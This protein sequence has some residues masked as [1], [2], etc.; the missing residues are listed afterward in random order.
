MSVPVV[1]QAQEAAAEA[2]RPFDIAPQ[3]VVDALA[4]FGRQSGLQV[5]MDADQVRGLSTQGVKGTMTPAQALDRLLASTGFVARI[6]GRIVSLRRVSTAATEQG[7]AGTVNLG[8]LRV[9]GEQA[10]GSGG[11]GRDG[12]VGT[13]GAAGGAAG[14]ADEIFA[15]PRA[16][17]ILTREEMDRAPA[18]HASDLLVTSPG[19]SSAV[20]RLDPGLSVNIR[21][22]QDFGRVNMMIDGMRQNFVRNGHQQRNGQVYVDPELISSVTIERGP[23]TDVHGAGAIAG[24]VNFRTLD[25][26][27]LLADEDDRIGARLRGSTGL[28]AEGNGVNFIGSAALAGRIG[29]RLELLGGYSRRSIGDYDVGRHGG[30][31]NT[32]LEYLTDSGIDVVNTI[33]YA[34]QVQDS[35]LFKARLNL[36]EDHWFQFTYAGTWVDYDNV[37]DM[38]D[39]VNLD[40]NGSPWRSLGPSTIGSE[41]FGLDY[42]FDPDSEWLDLNLK[43]YTVR[44]KN[45]NYS[46][47]RVPADSTTAMLSDFAW[48]LGF[49]ETDPIP[50]SWQMACTYG[51]GTDQ[52]IRTRTYGVQLDN[53]ARFDLAAGTQL[54]VNFGG[55]YYRDKAGSDIV[56]D[57]QGRVVET[58]NQ[59][60][61]GEL[62]N[63]DG[64]RTMGSAFANFTVAND[65]YTVAAGVRYDHYWLI[66]DTQIPGVQSSYQNRFDRFLEATCGLPQPTPISIEGC[67]VAQAGGEEAAAAWF[68]SIDRRDYWTTSIY[69][70]R[71]IDTPGMYDYHVD[72]SRGRFLPSISAAVRP[73]A[74]LE[75]YGSWAKSWRPPAINEALM[76]GGHPGDPLA[77]MYPNP[78][79]DPEKTTSWEVGA[80][81]TFSG[82]ATPDD[83]L[84]AKVGYFN[85][86][87]RDYLYTSL[88]S[89]L[90]GD[91]LGILLGLGRV[92]FVNNRAPTR[93]QGLEFEGRYDAGSVYANVAATI[94]LGKRNEFCQDLYPVGVG[95]SKYDQP[96]EDGSITAD[97]QMAL[98]AGYDSWQAWAEDQVV[99][100]NSVMNSVAGERVDRVSATLGV[101]LFDRRLDTG[102]RLM[103]AGDGGL[104]GWET[105]PLYVWDSYTTL[106]WYGSFRLG[107]RF[108]FFASAQNLTDRRYIDANGDIMAQ[109]LAPG[110]TVQAGLQVKF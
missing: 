15:A 43:L 73:T 22:M 12:R 52:T 3:S 46:N 89:N 98:D 58:Y 53:T 44:T 20:N 31:D 50:A 104:V 35:A 40:E 28:G 110:R 27:D 82:I 16:V 2:P 69:Q 94:Y 59:Y 90:P 45:R 61:Q 11:L 63:P 71:W 21:G 66:G 5:S 86:K 39:T 17:S 75:L 105:Q 13:G 19:V 83:V 30:G 56:I 80:N 103:H 60:G 93:F 72:S 77:N 88:N 4:D 51:Y 81:L 32:A 108:T 68:N 78:Y 101:R 62:L 6:E 18:R 57:R 1:T 23:R 42:R 8:P 38:R 36:G 48:D 24:T 79:A 7:Q 100:A 41:N 67:A 87:A 70:P 10:G 85:T 54:S 95:S 65:F 91:N 29:D 84:F 109:V 102:L 14:G 55:E 25:F 76:M 9:E 99:C 92:L 96:N 74:W 97:R 26:I 64:R 34:E 47:A 106:D 33:K 49:C 37:I 107:D